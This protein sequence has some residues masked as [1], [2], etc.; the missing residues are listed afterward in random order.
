MGGYFHFSLNI[1]QIS[2]SVSLPRA[3]FSLS[4]LSFLASTSPPS[5]PPHPQYNTYLHCTRSSRSSFVESYP[6]HL[7]VYIIVDRSILSDQGQYMIIQ[8]K[9]PSLRYPDRTTKA[10]YCQCINNEGCTNSRPVLEKRG[11]DLHVGHR[12]KPKQHVLS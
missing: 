9:V 1:I 5:S 10:Y 6:P 8:Q 11:E 2:I 7:L 12:I 4:A 3:E